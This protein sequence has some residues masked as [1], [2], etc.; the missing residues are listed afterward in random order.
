MH[1]GSRRRLT[2]RI[3]RLRPRRPRRGRRAH[4]SAG[5]ST[6]LTSRRSGVRVPLRPRLMAMS[7]GWILDTAAMS[8]AMSRRNLWVPLL[9]AVPVLFAAAPSASAQAAPTISVDPDGAH[10]RRGAQVTVDCDA[11]PAG[12][13]LPRFTVS[14]VPAGTSA[15]RTSSSVVVDPKESRSTR[16]GAFTSMSPAVTSAGR[17][18]GQTRRDG[19]GGPDRTAHNADHR[20]H[21]RRPRPRRRHR[22]PAAC[23]R[24]TSR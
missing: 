8:V 21:H 20:D 1:I 14:I 19:P 10:R 7:S 4:S 17:G 11:A 22:A 13:R 9:L 23:R 18:A 3:E 12:G 5:Q 24:P 2:G 6:C 15:R 16:P